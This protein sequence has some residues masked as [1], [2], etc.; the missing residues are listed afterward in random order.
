MQ[1]SY[2][3]V[4]EWLTRCS[5]KAKTPSSTLGEPTI[6]NRG[7][8]R[9]RRALVLG[10]RGQRAELCTPTNNLIKSNTY[11]GPVA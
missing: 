4:V 6:F 7:K 2:R 9:V 11:F 10:T 5:D 1:F 3:L 8:A